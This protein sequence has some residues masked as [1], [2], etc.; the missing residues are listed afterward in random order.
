[1]D[2]LTAE[3][4]V[5][6]EKLDMEGA[7]APQADGGEQELD[8]IQVQQGGKEELENTIETLQMFEFGSLQEAMLRPR[9]DE[10]ARSKAKAR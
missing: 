7:D 3:V 10:V 8:Q 9:H 6:G 2:S 1:M 5:N 4:E